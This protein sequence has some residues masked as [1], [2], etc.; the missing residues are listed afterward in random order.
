MVF[1]PVLCCM[2]LALLN[3]CIYNFAAKVD[4]ALSILLIISVYT[5]A[6]A[7]VVPPSQ[8]SCILEFMYFGAFLALVVMIS[9]LMIKWMLNEKADNNYKK[10][11]IFINIVSYLSSLLTILVILVAL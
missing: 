9:L 5:T 8:N 6:I 7:Q 3:L 4:N 10:P 11:P 1:I 2:C